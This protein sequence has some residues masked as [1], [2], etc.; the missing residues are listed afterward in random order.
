MFVKLVSYVLVLPLCVVLVLPGWSN[1]SAYAT[2]IFARN[3]KQNLSA[4]SEVPAA[5]LT[6]HNDA[7]RS[8]ANLN[9]SLLNTSN[10]NPVQFGKLFSRSVD[11]CVYAQPLYVP[12]VS[13]P[14]QGMHNVVYVASEHNSVYAYDADDPAAAAPLWQVNLGDSVPSTDISP[15]Y[16]DM[17][18]E[19]GITSTPVIDPLTGTIYV[20]AKSKDAGGYHQRLHALDISSG[21]EKFGGPAEIAASFEGTGD[22]NAGG[23]IHFDPLLQLNRPALLLLNGIVYIAFGSHGDTDPYHGWLMGY[24]ATTLQ[25]VAV[26]NTTPDGGRGAI[27][28]SGQGP[29]GDSAGH[30]YVTTANGTC[31]TNVECGRNLG[32]SFIKLTPTLIPVDWFTPA[33]RGD[34]DQEDN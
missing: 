34:L 30:V 23:T 29:S 14:Q 13:I 21:A 8:G 22:G 19:I 3:G 9:E 12:N 5:V 2:S 20:V 16:K 1:Q 10:V 31:D 15:D 25:Q 26:Y 4:Q 28:M 17:I 18:P 27:W 6:Q 7:S 11:G 32:E 24:N 33:N